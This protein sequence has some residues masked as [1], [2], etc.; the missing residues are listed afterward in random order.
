M[1]PYKKI[2]ISSVVITTLLFWYDFKYDAA[3]EATT[4]QM[5]ADIAIWGTAYVIAIFLVGS[6]LYFCCAKIALLF[7]RAVASKKQ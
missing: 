5:M 3:P 6:L 7:K 4:K 1:G 2:F